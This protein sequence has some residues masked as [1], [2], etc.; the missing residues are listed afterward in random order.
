VGE[1]AVASIDQNDRRMPMLPGI[2]KMLTIEII[3]SEFATS[4]LVLSRI[5]NPSS[6]AIAPVE[7]TIVTKARSNDPLFLFAI[8]F[9]MEQRLQLSRMNKFE[10]RTIGNS[11]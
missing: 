10:F 3:I 7:I 5:M 6:N 4:V 1:F 8:D 2:F 9:T 11:S